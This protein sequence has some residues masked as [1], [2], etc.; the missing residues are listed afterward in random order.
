MDYLTTETKERYIQG[1]LEL[2]EDIEKNPSKYEPRPEI[3]EEGTIVV[4][5]N[6]FGYS[7]YR[8]GKWKY[9]AGPLGLLQ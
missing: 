6:R 1:L 5:P 8:E 4:H 2:K 9:H 3:K 7:V